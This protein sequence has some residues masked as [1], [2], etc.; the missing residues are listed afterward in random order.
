MAL[1]FR[2]LSGSLL[3]LIT[4]FSQASD[5]KTAVFAGGCF[6]CMEPPFDA[7]NGVVRTTSGYIGGSEETANYKAISSGQTQHYEVIEVEYD[8][9]KVT[10]AELLQ[11]FWS[12]VDYHDAGGQFCDRGPQYRTGIFTNDMKERAEAERQKAVL[13]AELGQTIVTPIL[14]ADVFYP[15]EDYHQNYYQVNPV[16]YKYYR[17]RCGRDLRLEELAEQRGD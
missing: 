7:L 15:A 12:N 2:C 4:S 17:Y 6:W 1:M 11:V 9:V 5:T 14:T 10:Y 16:R 13:E 3:A 8:P